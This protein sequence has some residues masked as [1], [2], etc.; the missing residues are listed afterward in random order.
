MAKVTVDVGP[1]V[2]QTL[3][4]AG[5]AINN[6]GVAI[7]DR[8]GPVSVRGGLTVDN[9]GAGA[10]TVFL[11]LRKNALVLGSS[12]RTLIMVSGTRQA[13]TLEAVD[14]VAVPGDVY[15]I[16]ASVAAVVTPT[17]A[18]VNECYVT[19]EALSQDAALCAGI[20]PAT[21]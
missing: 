16:H 1:A 3:V 12:A 11:S 20:G 7:V 2:N 18:M 14:L 15:S 19:V 13:I 10:N 17:L 6:I 8:G 4:V 9:A 21:A 5:S